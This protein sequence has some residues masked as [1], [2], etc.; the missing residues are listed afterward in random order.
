MSNEAR[1]KI[2]KLFDNAYMIA[3]I[4]IPFTTF[5]SLYALEK[6]H[7]VCLGNM[8]QTDK[9]CKSFDELKCNISETVKS[10]CFIGVMAANG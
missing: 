1:L 5:Q 2:E 4:E 8:C 9:S 6:I 7:G 3:K 10:A